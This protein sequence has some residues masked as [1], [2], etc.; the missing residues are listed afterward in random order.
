[1]PDL[2]NLISPNS[3]KAAAQSTSNISAFLSSVSCY[4]D[5][6]ESVSGDRLSFVYGYLG[7]FS[8]V[9]LLAPHSLKHKYFSNSFILDH[10]I[11]PPSFKGKVFRLCSMNPGLRPVVFHGQF[12]SSEYKN[13][14][15]DFLKHKQ[16]YN[17]ISLGIQQRFCEFNPPFHLIVPPSRVISRLQPFLQKSFSSTIAENIIYFK[18]RSQPFTSIVTLKKLEA[19]VTRNASISF[20]S[21]DLTL[22]NLKSEQILFSSCA[23]SM[24]VVDLILHSIPVYISEF[25]PLYHF[26]GSYVPSLSP[27]ES[28]DLVYHIALNSSF[29]LE[30][31]A[32]V[33]DFL[34]SQ[35]RYSIT[36]SQ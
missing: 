8:K 2:F 3:T 33:L 26:L 11:A 1:M 21:N 4:H 22:R 20:R 6:V 18:N 36:T 32:D 23:T 27:K 29:S 12:H 10:S 31:F 17:C 19:I 25:H 30:R 15:F 34:S 13:L 35:P 7:Y 28:L 5:L 24:L 16:S 14:V 9:L